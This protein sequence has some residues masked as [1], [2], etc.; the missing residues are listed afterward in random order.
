MGEN[1]RP[2]LRAVLVDSHIAAVAIAVLLVWSLD[3]GFRALSGPFLRITDFLV[4]AVAILGIPYFSWTVVDRLSLGATLDHLFGSILNLAAA[5]LLSRW[6][7]G[8]GPVQAL[9][10]YRTRLPRR[11]DV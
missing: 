3:A 10:K 2:S 4:T 9:G 7:Y 1:V 11:S 8:T 6:A 5:W